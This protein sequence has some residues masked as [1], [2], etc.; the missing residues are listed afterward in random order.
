M[1]YSPA[2]ERVLGWAVCILIGLTGMSMSAQ[3]QTGANHPLSVGVVGMVHAHVDGLLRRPQ[4]DDIE[5]VGFVEPNRELGERLLK[6]YGYDLGMLYSSIEDLVEKTKPEAVATFT[7]IFDHLKVVQYC[8]PRGIHVMVEKPLAVSV[9]HAAKMIQLAGQYK[10]H[11]LTNYE[12]TWYASNAKAYQLINGDHEI[13][14]PRKMV[15]HT[16]H[17]GP[18]EIGCN[19]EFLDWLT[20][21]VLNGGG[22]LT[23][24][25]CYGAN[26]ATWL[27][28]GEEPETVTC[29]TQHLKPKLYPKVEDEATII[30]TYPQT[31]I[32]IQASWNWPF[33]RKDME[34]YGTG[35]SV[36][37]LN[38]TDLILRTDPKMAATP[39][40]AEP[41]SAGMDDPF[42]YLAAVVR[43]KITPKPYDLSD[44][45]NNAIVVKI[46]EAAKCSAKTGEQIVWKKY[47]KP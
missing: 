2:A 9:E 45:T 25:G 43:G 41:L 30:L 24:F 37:C 16:G 3:D 46:L 19:R 23:D 28:K 21:P 26:L 35:G 6:Q 18:I 34:V 12:T 22:A 15:F 33:A 10:I 17:A 31:Q 32:I 38:N 29:V 5:I 14:E 1:Q 39:L 20:D 8:A 42:G 4:R 7:T 36:L 11:L 13:G 27:M 40:H 47:F 44:V